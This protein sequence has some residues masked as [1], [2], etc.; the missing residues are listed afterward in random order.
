MH[1][2]QETMICMYH[3]ALC[4][5]NDKS[6]VGTCDKPTLN[7]MVLVS[8]VRVMVVSASQSWS[9]AI[10]AMNEMVVGCWSTMVGGDSSQ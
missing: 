9:M 8:L 2:A 7:R 5:D 6:C 3:Y 1:C 4:S 10:M